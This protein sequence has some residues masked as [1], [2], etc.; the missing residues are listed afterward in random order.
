[1]SENRYSAGVRDYR[2][3]YWEPD[4]APKET[5]LFACFKIVAQA[6][7]HSPELKAAMETW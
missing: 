2:E 1:M 3:T 4:Y 7:Q 6:S 5:D